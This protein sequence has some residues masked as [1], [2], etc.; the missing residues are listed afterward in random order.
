[1]ALVGIERIDDNKNKNNT[2]NNAMNRLTEMNNLN[3]INDK[4]KYNFII[5]NK[6]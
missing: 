5:W 3:N 1:M 4:F 2:D 6:L